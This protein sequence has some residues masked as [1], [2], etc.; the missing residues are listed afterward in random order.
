M[1]GNEPL[2]SLIMTGFE[3]AQIIRQNTDLAM[4]FAYRAK[5]AKIDKELGWQQ[6]YQY[7]MRNFDA[8]M[9]SIE[10]LRNEPTEEASHFDNID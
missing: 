10:E 9:H 6:V 3:K 4:T 1:R 5:Q 2:F 8:C 7:N